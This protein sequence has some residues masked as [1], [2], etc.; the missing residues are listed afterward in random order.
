MPTFDYKNV[1]KQIYQIMFQLLLWIS[2]IMPKVGE[3]EQVN[4][5]AI[6][7]FKAIIHHL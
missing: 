7:E 5:W 3:Q 1:R 4:N 2:Y 6:D